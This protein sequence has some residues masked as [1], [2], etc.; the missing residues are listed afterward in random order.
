MS[1]FTLPFV[2]KNKRIYDLLINKF[3]KNNIEYRPLVAG[4][5]LRQPFLE[6]YKFEYEKDRF[7]SDVVHEL[8]LYIGNSHFIGSKHLL[9]LKQILIEVAL[10]A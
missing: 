2:C 5:L 9:L 4:N 6:G 1:S 10:D 8:G 3:K 7:N